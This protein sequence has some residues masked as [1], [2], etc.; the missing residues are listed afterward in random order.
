MRNT[1]I[2]R[3]LQG[4][5]DNDLGDRWGCHCYVS[6][7]SLPGQLRSETPVLRVSFQSLLWDSTGELLSHV[8]MHASRGFAI[9]HL[10]LAGAAK[11]RP[12]NSFK[13]L[14]FNRVFTAGT[15]AII[16]A[17]YTLNRILNRP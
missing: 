5:F 11:T 3:G 17:F 10:F 13:T 16:V 2:E 8:E 7:Q 12:G 4:Q 1:I 6:F 14:D 9:F 15:D